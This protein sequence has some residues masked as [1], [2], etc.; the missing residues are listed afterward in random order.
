MKI[1]RPRSLFINMKPL[2]VNPKKKKLNVNL[3]ILLFI[4]LN[5]CVSSIKKISDN[6]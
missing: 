1:K 3:N 6:N 4:Y 2:R 5:K